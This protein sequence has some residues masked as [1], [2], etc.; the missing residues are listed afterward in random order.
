MLLFC[1][2]TRVLTFELFILGGKTERVKCSRVQTKCYRA[3]SSVE[4]REY[5]KG[6]KTKQNTTVLEI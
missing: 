1:L 3:Y 5:E 2:L 4:T 6:E